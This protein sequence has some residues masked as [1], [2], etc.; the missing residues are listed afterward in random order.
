[1]HRCRYLRSR[2]SKIKEEIVRLPH[3]IAPLPTVSAPALHHRRYFINQPPSIYIFYAGFIPTI[4]RYG[5]LNSNGIL[6]KK[7]S[8]I[9]SPTVQTHHIVYRPPQAALARIMKKTVYSV[10]PGQA[11]HRSPWHANG[12]SISQAMHPDRLDA[13]RDLKYTI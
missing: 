10:I 9:Y 5:I 7:C 11:G 4:R 2:Q 12:E 3:R 8:T 1:M 6:G 13:Q